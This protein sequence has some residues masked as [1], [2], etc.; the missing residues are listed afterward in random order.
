MAPGRPPAPD[1]SAGPHA[2]DEEL[3]LHASCVVAEGAAVL[4]LGPSGSGKSGL[5][6]QL[7]GM[8]AGLVADDRTRLWRE[9]DRV[10]AD[11][12]D[13]LRGLIEA[14][15]VGLLALPCAGPAPLALVV[16]MGKQETERLPE[17]RYT[18]VLGLDL[19]LTRKSNMAHFPAAIL[20]YLSG[21]RHA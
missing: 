10:M 20:A 19:P 2:A 5:A 8:G 1:P 7:I 13:R 21:D 16:D 12:P 15:Q 4:I 11:A 18:R 9:G 6:L 14:R 3:L 17:R